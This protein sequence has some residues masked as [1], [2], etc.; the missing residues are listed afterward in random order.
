MIDEFMAGGKTA[1]QILGD[2]ARVDNLELTTKSPGP[3]LILTT[4][5]KAKVC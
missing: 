5:H 1:H 3:L 2:I 4:V